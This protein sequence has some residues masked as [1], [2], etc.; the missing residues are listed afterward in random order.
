MAVLDLL[1]H[2]CTCC[3]PINIEHLPRDHV[4]LT[5]ANARTK[6]IV[7]AT[8][9]WPSPHLDDDSRHTIWLHASITSMSEKKSNFQFIGTSANWWL[10]CTDNWYGTSF[11]SPKGDVVG[12]N[13][14]SYYVH[15]HCREYRHTSAWFCS[16]RCVNIMR[17]GVGMLKTSSSRILTLLSLTPDIKQ[18]TAL[19]TQFTMHIQKQV[20][21][22]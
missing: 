5:K 10:Y 2:I 12:A 11:Q 19:L 6:P 14:H 4:L 8:C 9:T 7:T 17:S 13:T 21:L 18:P 22:R 20:I 3:I 16:F 1:Q 15:V